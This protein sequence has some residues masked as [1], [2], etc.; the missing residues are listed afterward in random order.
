MKIH[1]STLIILNPAITKLQWMEVHCV[2]AFTLSGCIYDLYQL[3]P[4]VRSLNRNTTHCGK[5]LGDLLT[6]DFYEAYAPPRFTR[7]V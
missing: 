6:L 2:G 3:F 4:A 5:Q 7:T 1:C